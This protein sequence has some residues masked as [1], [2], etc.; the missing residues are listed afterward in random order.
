MNNKAVLYT[1]VSSDEQ[2]KKG[3]SLD[4]Q[5]KQG[6]EYAERNNLQIVRL[7]TESFSAKKP[8]R[9]MFNEMMSY[10][11]KNKIYNL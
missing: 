4:Y 2:K 9:P 5:E 8:G 10:I 3:F 11:R 1:R 6:R 7:F